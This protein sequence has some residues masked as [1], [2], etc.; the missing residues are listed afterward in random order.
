ML[1]TA[2]LYLLFIHNGDGTFQNSCLYIVQPFLW[3][4]TFLYSY[5]KTFSCSPILLL[6]NRFYLFLYALL[7]HTKV[8]KGP[9][10]YHAVLCMNMFAPVRVCVP[11]IS[12]FKPF[13]RFLRNLARRLNHL[14]D[15]HEN[16][17]QP[18]TVGRHSNATRSNCLLSIVTSRQ[19]QEFVRKEQNS[20]TPF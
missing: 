17:Y 9:W 11:P 19:T 6:L 15:F 1:L 10:N 14:N 8:I 4:L 12:N 7:A 20:A 3:L 5:L 2:P 16:C 18:Y 13:H